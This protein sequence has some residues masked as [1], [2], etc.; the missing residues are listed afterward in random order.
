MNLE[1]SFF[2]PIARECESDFWEELLGNSKG[3][4][5]LNIT[6]TRELKGL[7]NPNP[8]PPAIFSECPF[9]FPSC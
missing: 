9:T 5:Y 1:S 2:R 6:G 3:N 8:P 7:A 4:L